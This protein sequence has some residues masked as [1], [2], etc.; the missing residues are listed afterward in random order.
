M[1]GPYETYV[2]RAFHRCGS[3]IVETFDIGNVN[4]TQ[5]HLCGR[6]GFKKLMLEIQGLLESRADLRKEIQAIYIENVLNAYL[7]KSLPTMGFTRQPGPDA[8][9]YMMLKS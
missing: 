2:R 1:L 7:A 5:V 8:S 9:F 6:G 3:N 4:N